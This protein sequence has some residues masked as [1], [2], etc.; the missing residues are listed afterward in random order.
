VR[1]TA[2]FGL[3]PRG[4]A[5]RFPGVAAH[6]WGIPTGSRNKDA[7]WEFIKWSMSKELIGRI[8][9]EKGYGSVTRRSILDSSGFRERMKVNGVDV[10]KLY[11]DTI[12]EAERGYMRYRTIHVFPQ[13]D[14]QIT[15]AIERVVSGQMGARESMRQAQANTIAD[16]RRA[17]IR[18]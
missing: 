4:P 6:G 12:A 8:V 3:M 9:R 16:L 5:G 10:T 7:A 2:D 1:D 18:F 17:G 13:A 11:L 14:A 15:Q